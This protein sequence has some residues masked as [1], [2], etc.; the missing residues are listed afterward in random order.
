MNTFSMPTM[1]SLGIRLREAVGMDVVQTVMQRHREACE[2]D[3]APGCTC[4]RVTVRGIVYQVI[5]ETRWTDEAHTQMATVCALRDE[6]R[7]LTGTK[8]PWRERTDV[9]H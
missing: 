7:E 3:G 2:R 8:P 6:W 1:V 9:T 4:G 5:T